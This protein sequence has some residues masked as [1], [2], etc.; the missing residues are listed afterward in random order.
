MRLGDIFILGDHVLAC[1]DARDSKLVARTCTNKKIDLV[2]T[3]PPYGVE[4]VASKS[5]FSR[6]AKDKTIAGDETTSESAYAVFS[7]AWLS[8][9]KA[10]LAKKNTYYIFNSDKMVFA[11]RTA[12]LS[13]GFKFTQLLVWV[14]NHGVI[15]RM[16]YLPQHELIAY[17]WFG[18]HDFK[19][20]KDKSVLY[21]P[22]PSK[23]VLHPTMK[24]V[25]LLRKLILNSTETGAVVYDPF[26]GSGSTLIACEHVGRRAV[27]IELDTEYCA[28][29]IKRWERLTG[30]KA[31][32]V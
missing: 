29:I 24:P 32:R 1:G 6:I 3:D 23:S 22:K 27:V 11:L 20:S 31:I 8:V 7:S 21:Y 28:T 16:D 4:Y 30:K 14:K 5:G 13:L 9:A 25:G 12:L 17:G 26:G 19:H 10:H 15:G 18:T 2:L